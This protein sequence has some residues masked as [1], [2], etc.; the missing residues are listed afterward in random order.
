MKVLA[1]S[2]KDLEELLDPRE[3]VEA[4][5]KAFEMASLGR[6]EL[7]PRTVFYVEG[8]WWGIMQS[9]VPGMGVGVKLV[10][11]IPKNS[12]RGLPTIHAVTVLADPDKGMPLAI[13]E[14][15]VLTAH[16]TAAASAL[17]IKL[18]AP[19]EKGKIA[20][21]GTGYQARYQLR[22]ALEFFD[23][24]EIN[25]YDIKEEAMNSFEEFAKGLGVKVRKCSSPKEATKG[26]RVIIEAS[27]TK[28]EVI[29]Y[30]SIEP[31][32]HVISIGA[33]TP[34][35]RAIE[36]KVLE[37]AEIICV[38]SRKACY[39]EAGDIKIPVDSGKLKLEELVEIGEIYSGK[40]KIERGQGITVFKSVGLSVQDVAAANLAYLR[41]LKKGL[42]KEIEL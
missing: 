14:G 15:G 18:L 5:G 6:A 25:I 4:V 36:D 17:S 30:D 11:I 13:L 40:V 42:G 34:Q 32:V 31:P 9:Y 37:E 12:E 33:H 1:I 26:A 3:L 7:P 21:I 24:D 8:N 23:A 16:R 19:K 2:G 41:A 35:A 10:N 27:T 22:Y 20:I 28:K 29:F 38:D 39:E